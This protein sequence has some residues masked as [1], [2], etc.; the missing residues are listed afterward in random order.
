MRIYNTLK[1]K[2]EEFKPVHPG[3]VR[4]YACGM[5]VQAE[6]HM[7][8]MRTFVSFDVVRRYFIYKGFKVR[9]VSNFTD[10]DDKIIQKSRETGVDW[11]DI[12]RKNEK[13]FWRASRALNVM[14]PDHVPRATQHI[15]EIIE[16]IEAIL[17]RGY[18]YVKEGNVYFRVRKFS[19]Y[20]KLSGKRIE[21]LREG[22]RVEPDPLKEDPLDFALWKARKP[23]EP[24]WHSPWGPGRPGWHI[25]CSAM[26]THYLGQP[27][28]IHGGGADLIFPHHE[29]EIAQAEAARGVEFARYWMHG[30]LLQLGGE[31]MS[32]STGLYFSAREALAEFNP[33]AI[34]LYFLQHHYRSPLNYSEEGLR[35]AERAWED[36]V[37]PLR[38]L[39][40]VPQVKEFSPEVKERLRAFEEAM[41][42]D[43]NAPKALAQVFKLSDEAKASGGDALRERQA[44]LALLLRVLGF[45]P[46]E[47][48]VGELA[49]ELLQLVIDLRQELRKRREFDLAD[50]VRERLRALGIALEDTPQGTRWRREV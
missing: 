24:Y 34:R 26:S 47:E 11:R 22:A 38:G 16:M 43:F 50:R 30:G 36:L 4:I 6:P 1:A 42:D 41:D 28:D 18:A 31:K 40:E 32:K 49:E 25:E 29:N 48:G 13:E 14:P 37:S 5:T 12:G 17:E 2:K 44:A 33:N 3:E 19:G 20:G 9:F 7:G 35:A 15:Q 21:E 27:F 10:I 39:K 45:Q 8:H 46:E 23:G